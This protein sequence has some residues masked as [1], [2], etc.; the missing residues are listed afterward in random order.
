MFTDQNILYT[1]VYMK[2][3][4]TLDKVDLP[5]RRC[6]LENVFFCVCLYG[7]VILKMY[8]SYRIADSKFRS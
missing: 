7:D 8:F 2:Q 3:R 1:F 4:R 5:H 6:S